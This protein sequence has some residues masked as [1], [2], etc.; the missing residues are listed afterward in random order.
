MVDILDEV[1]SDEK[2]EK[3][4]HLFRKILPVIITCSLIIACLIAGYGWY[5]N[6]N[7]KHNQNIGDLLINLVLENSKDVKLSTE[8]L[9]ELTVKSENRQAELAQIQLVNTFLASKNSAA[10]KTK[11]VEIINNA[12]YLDLTRSYARIMWLSI[13][14]TEDNLSDEDQNKTKIFL[15]HFDNENLVFF[16]TATIMKSLY[17]KKIG[18]MDLAR[19]YAEQLVKSSSIPLV[20]KEQASALLANLRDDI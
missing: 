2:H 9:E 5:K 16:G 12:N 19:Q 4:L 11:L 13:A 6:R 20:I 1:L 3:R 17:Y 14:L 15:D 8:S 18:Q 7:T 10:A